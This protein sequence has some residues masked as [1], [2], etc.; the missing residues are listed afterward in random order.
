MRSITNI[1]D[2]FAKLSQEVEGLLTQLF[3]AA[4]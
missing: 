1:K 4:K 3:W 2:T